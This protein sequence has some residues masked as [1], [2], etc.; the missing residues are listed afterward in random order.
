MPFQYFSLPFEKNAL[1]PYISERTM[2]V[3]Y[4]G[5]YKKYVSNLNE[6]ESEST[7]ITD[8][9]EETLMKSHNFDKAVF[10]NAA[11]AW[12]HEFYWKCLSP[13]KQKPLDKTLAILESQFGSLLEFIEKFDKV[14]LNL[15]GSG[16]VWIVRGATGEVEIQ[17]LE[18]AENPLTSGYKPLLV[19][20]V[21]E[22]AYYLDHQSDRAGY[23]NQFWKVI[24]WKFLEQNVLESELPTIQSEA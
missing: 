5:H 21:W 4:E 9:L 11:Q 6:L 2:T 10:Q 1:E 15:F 12:N 23:L 3:H 24:N 19:C 14:A 20:D 22:H 16:W 7:V 8:S 17:A 18:K 13:D